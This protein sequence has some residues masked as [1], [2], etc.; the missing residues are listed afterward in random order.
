MLNIRTVAELCARTEAEL[1]GVKNFG[2]TSLVEIKER[3]TD[4]GLSLR[5]VE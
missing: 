5:D 2:Q 1:M 4:M 3:L